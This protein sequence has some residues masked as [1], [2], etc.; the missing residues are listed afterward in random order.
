MAFT[1]LASGLYQQ[2]ERIASDPAYEGK[3]MSDLPLHWQKYI[4]SQFQVSAFGQ[5]KDKVKMIMKGTQAVEN[6]RRALK[7]ALVSKSDDEQIGA[8]SHLPH[9]KTR[10]KP[11]AFPSVWEK[12]ADAI[13]SCRHLV[14]S[15]G[16]ASNMALRATIAE[17]W[18]E[19][20]GRRLVF[21]PAEYCVDNAVMIANMG[22]LMYDEYVDSNTGAR[23]ES[24]YA[25]ALDT[26][27][28]ARW[29]MEDLGAERR[30]LKTE[31]EGIAQ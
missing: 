13:A 23:K 15:G 31:A 9:P 5:L 19:D 3:K 10:W 20:D 25:Q 16:V 24:R 26:T 6:Q 2:E 11:K 7:A 27:P 29:S 14:V 22:A 17:V 4:A 8:S 1:G 28:R 21:P 12:S 30:K 18:R